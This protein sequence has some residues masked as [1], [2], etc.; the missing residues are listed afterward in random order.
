MSK[1]APAG[2]KRHPRSERDL[3]EAL[4]EHIGLLRE[5]GQRAFEEG[6]RRYLGEVAAKLRL[7]CYR[8]GR[9]RPLLLDMMA[10]Y[11]SKVQVVSSFPPGKTRPLEEYLGELSMAIPGPNGKVIITNRD[12]VGLWAQQRGAAHEDWEHSDEMVALR[13][14]RVYIGGLHASE[15]SL[16]AVYRTVLSVSN[17]FLGELLQKGLIHAKPNDNT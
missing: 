16:R 2:R 8:K 1:E 3:G 10:R 17:A 14:Q 9:N 13:Y 15:A 7:L 5:Y 4:L 12:L 11:D 6:D